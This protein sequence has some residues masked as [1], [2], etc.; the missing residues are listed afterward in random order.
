MNCAWKRLIW[1]EGGYRSEGP[2]GGACAAEAHME[3]RAA[4]VED[5]AVDVE[6]RA[7]DVEER[8]WWRPT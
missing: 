1:Y 5:H 4:D 7:A 3:E 6:E 2:H 8:V